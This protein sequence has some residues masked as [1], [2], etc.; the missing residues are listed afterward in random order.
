MP[1]LTNP[2]DIARE[3]LKLLSSRRLVPTPEN[4]LQIYHEIAGTAVP[5]S[6]LLV[7]ALDSAAANLPDHDALLELRRAVKSGTGEE[8]RDAL[9]GLA[10]QD[11][12]S[13]SGRVP[14]GQALPWGSLLRDVLREL[15]RRQSASSASRKKEGL[16]RLLL[17]FSADP[18]LFDKLQNLYR[19]WTEQGS[20]GAVI[21]S[22][23]GGGD[24]V[25]DSTKEFTSDAA[26]PDAVP[27]SPGS[28]RQ[29][30]DMLT[31]IL[32][33]GVA[34]RLE[35]F[36][37]LAL[38]AREIKRL[39]VE[40]DGADAWGKVAT[41]L[42][43]FWL[44]VELRTDS[45]SEVIDNLM[46]VLGLLT[47]NLGELVDDDQ[48]VGGQIAILQNLLSVPPTKDVLQEAERN[49]KE[50]IFRQG[51]LKH[52][53]KDA[54]DTLK[55]LV[56][57]F[58]ERL[59]E[60]TA[61]TTG[62]QEK[63]AVYST[64]IR[65]TD[66]MVQLKTIIDELMMDTRVMQVDMVRSRDELLETRRKADEAQARVKEL[67]RTL[68]QVSEQVREDALTGMLNRR[69]L[70]DA[71]DTELARAERTK[72]PLCVAVLDIDNFK[73]LNDTH[74]HQAGDEALVHLARVVKHT[75]RPTD[76]VARYGGEE[77]IVLYGDTELRNAIEVTERLQRE[78][79][80]RFFLH[81]NERLLITF[82]AGVAQRQD[83]EGKEDLFAR[84]DKAMY[85]AKLQGKNRVVA[86]T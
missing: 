50:I 84:A 64:R 60:V 74:G 80:K 26:P 59:T 22:A 2:T 58:I 23:S 39:A 28:L 86:A 79:T 9:Q 5:S 56:S 75:V 46:R 55:D 33:N 25:R 36:P 30:R 76:V 24:A 47:N 54:R 18:T 44:K 69:G 4:Y 63:I 19:S 13:N 70:D 29:L 20:A 40:A 73:K 31:S 71:F 82:S 27:A 57:V 15:E 78:L 45:E 65:S 8:I 53:L 67:E 77:F 17:N 72:K 32:E 61:S 62:Y 85:Q 83:G 14:G 41:Q 49:F 21:E 3:T 11:G 38:E 52:S 34:A 81:H 6:A 43:S 42:K 68:T 12:Q 37:E 1:A 48:W 51:S 35:R 7:Q 10:N 16:D 66:N